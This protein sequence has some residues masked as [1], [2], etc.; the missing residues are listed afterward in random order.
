MNHCYVTDNVRKIY[1]L[2]VEHKPFS[3]P[4][5]ERDIDLLRA[6]AEGRPGGYDTACVH[7][8]EGLL[9]P[10]MRAVFAR[11]H[12]QVVDLISRQVDVNGQ[13]DLGC[14]SLGEPWA[15]FLDRQEEVEN[16]VFLGPLTPL[17]AA[18]MNGDLDCVRILHEAGADLNAVGLCGE[19]A[20][21]YAAHGGHREIVSYLLDN[22][23]QAAPGPR[24]QALCLADARNREQVVHLLRQRN[25]LLSLENFEHF[26]PRDN[27]AP[28]SIA[29]FSAELC[30]APG[31]AISAGHLD[32]ARELMDHGAILDM[33]REIFKWV[34]APGDREHIAFLI[35]SGADIN[36]RGGEDGITPLMRAV[37]S[38]LENHREIDLLL[39]HGADPCLRDRKHRSV[40]W[41]MDR[42]EEF[43]A[44]ELQDSFLR[45]IAPML[46]DPEAYM[47]DLEGLLI[48]C[49]RKHKKVNGPEYLKSLLSSLDS[50]SVP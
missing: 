34:V 45:K 29:L 46:G 15:I 42:S 26:L 40:I 3:I 1:G 4:M 38:F 13:C 9:M 25:M 47:E 6:F 50:S 16:I 8:P 30:S 17:M 11:D 35:E 21:V 37:Q 32:I 43:W 28:I 22:H 39:D 48:R 12:E 49:P 7:A 14:R 27:R 33:D 2:L 18:V 31:K 24:E 10:L 20:M 41:H 44:S 5:S 19:T 36:A 23:A